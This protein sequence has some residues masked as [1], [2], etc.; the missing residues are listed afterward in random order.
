MNVVQLPDKLKLGCRLFVLLLAGA[1][2]SLPMSLS[3][4]EAGF[5]VLRSLKNYKEFQ[6]WTADCKGIKV[7]APKQTVQCTLTQQTCEAGKCPFEKQSDDQ[8]PLALTFGQSTY[9]PTCAWVFN[10]TTWRYVYQCW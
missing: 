3:A 5:L 9:N 8:P 4:Q 7:P 1:C 10:W 2:T 6:V